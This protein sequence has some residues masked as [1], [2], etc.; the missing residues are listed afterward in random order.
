MKTQTSQKAITSKRNFTL[1]LILAVLA[2]LGFGFAGTANAA[3][4]L[5]SGQS[6]VQTYCLNNIDSKAIE[7]CKGSGNSNIEQT[8]N[9]ASYHCAKVTSEGG[10]KTT[11]IDNN[12]KKLI[13]TALKSNPKSVSAFERELHSVLVRDA[14]ATGG[15]LTTI[16]PDAADASLAPE[17]TC[18]AGQPCPALTVDP[19]ACAADPELSGC[20]V[21]ADAICDDNVCDFVKKYVNPAISTVSLIFGLIVA[22]SLIAGGIQYSAAGGDPQKV[23]SA[24]QRITNTIVALIAYAFLYGFLQFLVPG[25]IF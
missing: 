24:K 16:S 25:G 8:R 11:C 21:N 13:R 15:S 4:T 9:V 1:G 18:A 3:D 20:T 2:V 14:K 7:A 23:S 17:T 22:I 5:T 6:A 19:A 12:G 10:K